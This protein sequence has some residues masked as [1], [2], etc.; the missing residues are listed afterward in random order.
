MIILTLIALKASPETAH[1]DLHD[2]TPD[3]ARADPW[4]ALPGKVS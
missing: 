4:D 2:D 1:R 3:V